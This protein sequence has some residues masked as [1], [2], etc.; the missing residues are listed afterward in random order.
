MS[1]WWKINSQRPHELD[2][3]P[4]AKCARSGSSAPHQSTFLDDRTLL[5][6]H[7]TN[8][9][10]KSLENGQFKNILYISVYTVPNTFLTTPK[11]PER[12]TK[13]VLNKQ[14]LFWTH[15]SLFPRSFHTHSGSGL[16]KKVRATTELVWSVHQCSNYKFTVLQLLRREQNV[17][18]YSA[19]SG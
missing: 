18:R 16:H 8:I 2:I 7:F 15:T 5:R 6:V 9:E 3:S 14:T 13:H 19:K 11:V 1:W 10:A 17:S 4:C 12:F